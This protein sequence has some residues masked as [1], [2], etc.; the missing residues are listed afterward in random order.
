MNLK[1]ARVLVTGGAGVICSQVVK[2]FCEEKVQDAV[3]DKLSSCRMEYIKERDKLHVFKGDICETGDVSEALL[4][5][6]RFE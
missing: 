1:D 2:Q 6:A 3:L 5:R 4:I